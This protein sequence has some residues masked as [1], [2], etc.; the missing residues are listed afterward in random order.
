MIALFVINIGSG[1][2]RPCITAFGGDQFIVPQQLQAVENFFSAI[3]LAINAATLIAVF[4][5][6]ILREDVQCFGEDSCFALG[7]G[8]PAVVMIAAL[9]KRNHEGIMIGIIFIA[10]S[11][12]PFLCFL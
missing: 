9:G 3:Y 11:F 7:F 12:I 6:P 2:I 5:T 10:L 8:V 1:G 4:V